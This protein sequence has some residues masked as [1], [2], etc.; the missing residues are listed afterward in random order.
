M[1]NACMPI[2]LS[3]ELLG[4]K[5]TSWLS[6]VKSEFQVLCGMMEWTQSSL[7]ALLIALA[8]SE[9]WSA[10]LTPSSQWFCKCLKKVVQISHGSSMHFFSS[11]VFISFLTTSHIA[12]NIKLLSNKS[13]KSS[14]VSVKGPAK[15]I[16]LAKNVTGRLH[17]G[18]Q[19]R[20]IRITSFVFLKLFIPRYASASGLHLG[21]EVLP[22]DISLHTLEYIEEQGPMSSYKQFLTNVWISDLKQEH[23]HFLFACL[24]ISFFNSHF[25]WK[26]NLAE[27]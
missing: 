15:R 24:S 4:E 11:L 17:R 18:G 21:I 16:T 9:T 10:W 22:T 12:E 25:P 7:S 8:H 23:S 6:R 27:N 19:N 1:P 5:H 2:T 14:A 3:N 26:L 13:T 20:P